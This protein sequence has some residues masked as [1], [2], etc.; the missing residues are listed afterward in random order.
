M[1]LKDTTR[2]LCDANPEPVL[3]FVLK[4]YYYLFYLA[5]VMM[6]FFFEAFFC[7][8]NASFDTNSSN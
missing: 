2:F 4:A 6:L 5:R 7:P 8:R 1:T 3:L